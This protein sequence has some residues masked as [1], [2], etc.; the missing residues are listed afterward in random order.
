V[1]QIGHYLVSLAF[2]GFIFLGA[3]AEGGIPGIWRTDTIAKITGAE[4]QTPCR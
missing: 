3:V 4:A 2:A 1:K